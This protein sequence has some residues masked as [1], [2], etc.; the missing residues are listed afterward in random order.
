MSYEMMII[1]DE[2]NKRIKQRREGEEEEE[3]EEKDNDDNGDGDGDEG[4]GKLKGNEKNWR[5]QNNVDYIHS[6]K[7]KEI[8]CVKKIAVS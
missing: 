4:K 1:D 7:S 5:K 2:R 3:E 8:A 6:S